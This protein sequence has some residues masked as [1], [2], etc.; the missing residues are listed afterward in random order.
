[1]KP[2][3]CLFILR[4]YPLERHGL[5]EFFD[6]L[7]TFKAFDQCVSLLFLDRSVKLLDLQPQGRPSKI[8]SLQDHQLALDALSIPVTIIARSEWSLIIERHDLV[9]AL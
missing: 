7:L 6:Q 4:A 3:R 1:M 5:Q 2:K 8:Q 9:V